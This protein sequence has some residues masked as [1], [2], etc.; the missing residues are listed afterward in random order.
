MSKK[1]KKLS[2]KKIRKDAIKDVCSNKFI[3]GKFRNIFDMRDYKDEEVSFAIKIMIKEFIKKNIPSPEEYEFS[4]R[5]RDR[6]IDIDNF[7]RYD[8]NKSKEIKNGKHPKVNKRIDKF[9]K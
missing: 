3:I 1:K 7:V 5:L 2:K 8:D 6:N 9:F 4:R